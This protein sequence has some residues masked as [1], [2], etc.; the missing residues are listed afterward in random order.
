M[1]SEK[2]DNMKSK[3]LGCLIVLAILLSGCVGRNAE[4]TQ[5]LFIEVETPPVISTDLPGDA[6][7]IAL[8]MKTLTNPFFVEMERGARQAEAEFGIH[9]IVKTAA[10][11]TSI[12]QQINIVEEL[13]R[14]QVDAIVIAPGDSIELIP[15][16]KEAQDA[17]IVVINIDNQLDAKL[18]QEKGLVNIP[19]ISVDNEAGAY[20]A[21]KNLSEKISSPVEAAII[22]GIRSARNADDRK[23]GALRAFA[24]NDNI[25][26]VGME[27]ANW[28]IDEAY[29][30]S[31]NLFET[32]P[33]IGLVFC[34]N[35]MMALGVVEYLQKTGRTDV[36]VAG[37]DAL[38]EAVLAV[39]E[40]KL[41]VTVDQQPAQQGFLGVEYALKVLNGEAVPVETILD[42][43]VV[44][45]ESLD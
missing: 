38:D 42:V 30:V 13:I 5:D 1:K 21:V 17:G 11:E 19:Y 8:V 39:R 15:A 2:F 25:T 24:E 26:V 10:Q 22:E 29:E 44:D 23:N 14:D 33:E 32:H 9:L 6:P 20:K 18:S 28:K 41:A 27:S 4:S 12:E 36:L 35:D 7:R 43:V 3:Y 16:L 45:L 31:R 34:A 37:Y 40:G